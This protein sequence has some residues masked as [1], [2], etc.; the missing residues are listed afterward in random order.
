MIDT[1]WVRT[2][3]SVRVGKSTQQDSSENL[4]S[5]SKSEGATG[6][7][8]GIDGDYAIVYIAANITRG[9]PPQEKI[10]LIQCEKA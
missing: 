3:I 7:V 2:G 1:S 5:F 4:I 9:K 10:P 8:T 6:Y